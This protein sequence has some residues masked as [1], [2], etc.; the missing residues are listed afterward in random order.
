MDSMAEEERKGGGK[1]D[2]FGTVVLVETGEEEVVLQALVLQDSKIMQNNTEGNVV[3]K[4]WELVSQE[5]FLELQVWELVSLE[6]I[7]RAYR[8][9][10]DQ[11]E[12][13]KD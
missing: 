5:L 3:L 10:T 9:N 7:Q 1:K 2:W 4:A 13:R 11:T 8:G 6:D 12:R